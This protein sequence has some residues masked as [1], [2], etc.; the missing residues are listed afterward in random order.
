MI[1]LFANLH[2]V[3]IHFV[4]VGYIVAFLA[5]VASY[6]SRVDTGFALKLSLANFW[7]ATVSYPVVSLTG[8]ID[9]RGLNLAISR[10]LLALKIVTGMV[11]AILLVTLLL[12]MGGRL[13]SA[14]RLL[15]KR[16]IYVIFSL[17]IMVSVVYTATLG[18]LYVF[19][20]S[21]FDTFG[22]G[23]IVITQVNQPTT[24]YFSTALEALLF[25]WPATAVL[26]VVWVVLVFII[27]R[28]LSPNQ[29][30]TSI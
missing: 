26:V 21:L 16:V 22:L 5:V 4:I 10:D 3:V 17:L 13:L 19:G 27:R 11:T 24:I 15:E 25:S 30:G 23:F 6:F 7:M 1:D 28:F 29:A 2:P 8:M 20:H 18:G 12:T 9:A 14:E